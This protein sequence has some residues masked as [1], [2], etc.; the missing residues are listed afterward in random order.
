MNESR[1][2]PGPHPVSHLRPVCFFCAAGVSL[3]IFAGLA[4]LGKDGAMEVD[5]W[6]A[7][8]MQAHADERGWLT[9]TA[10][11][12]TVLGDGRVLAAVAALGILLLLARRDYILAIAWLAIVVGGGFLNHG[13]KWVVHRERPAEEMRAVHAGGWSFPSGH[14]MGSA[15]G[16]G[17]VFFVVY[18][19]ARNR[20]T[21]WLVGVLLIGVIVLI[22]FTRI[23]LRVHWFSDVLGGFALGTGWLLLGLGIF[24][25]LRARS[26]YA[27]TECGTHVA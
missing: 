1:N 2:Q 24:F 11:G 9:A 27:L 10:A 7:R 19:R 12:I 21:R 14:A 23:Y 15:I 3:L 25:W 4:L 18:R 8:E 5:A 13:V 26:T 16:Y 22:G 17:M 20:V 6:M